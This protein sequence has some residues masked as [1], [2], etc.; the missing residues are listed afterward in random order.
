M[1]ELDDEVPGTEENT[2]GEE[3]SQ[4][5]KVSFVFTGFYCT[6]GQSLNFYNTETRIFNKGSWDYQ[7]NHSITLST[8]VQPGSTFSF[9]MAAKR[10]SV[11]CLLAFIA[12]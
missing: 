10:R 7:I 12:L 2:D 1:G 6:M 3:T 9:G 8:Y 11:L 5:E 4:N